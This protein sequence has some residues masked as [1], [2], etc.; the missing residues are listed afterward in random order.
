MVIDF[1]GFKYSSSDYPFNR[2]NSVSNKLFS[3]IQSFM[4]FL[5][6]LWFCVGLS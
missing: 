1:S 3:M 2:G 4:M 6:S 5:K